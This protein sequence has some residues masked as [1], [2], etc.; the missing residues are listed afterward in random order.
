MKGIINGLFNSLDNTFNSTIKNLSFQKG[1]NNSENTYSSL[2]R[3]FQTI[4]IGTKEHLTG[5]VR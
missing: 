3:C 4:K 5:K 1:L 2:N